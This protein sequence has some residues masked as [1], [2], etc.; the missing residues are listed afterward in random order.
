MLDFW[1][2]GSVVVVDC[3]VDMMC[4]FFENYVSRWAFEVSSFAD[5]EAAVLTTVLA[6]LLRRY[7]D[8]IGYLDECSRDLKQHCHVQIMPLL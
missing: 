1:E 4:S 6:T 8:A 2:R 3:C 5:T 7:L